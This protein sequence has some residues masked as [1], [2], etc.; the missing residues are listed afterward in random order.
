VHGTSGI[1]AVVSMSYHG[2]EISIIHTDS[3]ESRV[4]ASYYLSLSIHMSWSTSI[5]Y[6]AEGKEK[7]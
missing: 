2:M 3:S 4:G 6:L 7:S 1:G 5:K